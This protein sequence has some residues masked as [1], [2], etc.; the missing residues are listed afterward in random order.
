M[1]DPNNHRPQA[2]TGLRRER[3]VVHDADLREALAKSRAAADGRAPAM[4]DA[5]SIS[6]ENWLRANRVVRDALPADGVYYLNTA[7][8]IYVTPGFE[9]LSQNIAPWDNWAEV[10]L[11]RRAPPS[12]AY[13]DG[14]V[15]FSFSWENSTG[16]A[17][18]FNV[19][20]LLGV[21]ANC[22]VTADS[23]WFPTWTPPASWLFAH[24]DL[25]IT[26][27]E[28][29]HTFEP[30]YQPNQTQEILHNFRVFGSWGVGTI[31]GQDVF[32]TYIL[33]YEGLIVP[34]NGRVE[35]DLSCYVTWYAYAGGGFFIAAGRGRRV[36][37]WGVIITTAPWIIE[38]QGADR[39]TG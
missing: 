15:T 10:I 3:S 38:R 30:A 32:R 13:F 28:D 25:R 6:A 18:M 34:A 39:V 22:I 27:V 14:Q 8:R 24:A 2:A 1:A 36:T 4:R 31:A 33:P 16:Q 19:N 11:D 12:G 9:F 20:A 23:Y 17:N 37:G 5:V 21:T 26:V 35:F 29:G 7:D